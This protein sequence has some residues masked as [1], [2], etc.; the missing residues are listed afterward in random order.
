M[1]TQFAV[2]AKPFYA[3]NLP[4]PVVPTG[5]APRQIVALLA[6]A[7]QREGRPS[8]EGFERK[9]QVRQTFRTET[10]VTS[11]WFNPKSKQVIETS[12]SLG[13]SYRGPVAVPE[14]LLITLT[15]AYAKAYPA[16]RAQQV[17]DLTRRRDA[18]RAKSRLEIPRLAA[19][20][21]RMQADLAVL[22]LQLGALTSPGT[23]GPKVT[24]ALRASAR[25]TVTALT[26]EREQT[27]A[28][29]QTARFASP[30]ALE[31]ARAGIAAK[32]AVLDERLAAVAPYAR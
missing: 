25:E 8:L 31:K 2:G 22:E 16:E 18:L 24:P 12:E 27:R 10:V 23:K 4:R 15:D 32:V 1:H 30:E 3:P 19:V 11:L 17:A 28:L 29:L 20:H 14:E 21:E 13:L 9:H 5:F 6:Q 26:R 7:K